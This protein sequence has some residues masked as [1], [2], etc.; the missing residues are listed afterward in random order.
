M[1]V[2]VLGSATCVKGFDCIIALTGHGV[3]KGHLWSEATDR[4]SSL[5]LSASLPFKYVQV[6]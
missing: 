3:G 2:Q 1:M 6:Y 5:F 4:K